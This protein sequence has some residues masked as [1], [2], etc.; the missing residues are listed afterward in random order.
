M[1]K[2]QEPTHGGMRENAGRK[3]KYD[4]PTTTVAVRVPESLKEEITKI[5][6]KAIKKLTKDK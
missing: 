2:A 6:E 4:E 3:M 1:K 5:V